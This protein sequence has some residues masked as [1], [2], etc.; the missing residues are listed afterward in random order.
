MAVVPLGVRWVKA[1]MIAAGCSAPS[2]GADMAVTGVSPTSGS[3]TKDTPVQI[4]GGGFHGTLTNNLDNGSAVYDGTLTA[5]V[6]TTT[7]ADA[8]RVDDQ[9]ISATVPAGITPGTYDVTVTVGPYSDT[10]PGAFTV[11]PDDVTTMT[12]IASDPPSSAGTNDEFV[13]S[14]MFTHVVGTGANR[15]LLVGL[16]ISFAGTTALSV[17]S[18]GTAMTRV[19]FVNALSNDGRVE[20]WRLVAPPSGSAQISIQLSNASSSTVAGAVSFAN[21]DQTTPLGPFGGLANNMGDPAHTAASM[22][23][24]VVFGVVMWNGGYSGTLSG[25]QP[26]AWNLISAD[27]VGAACTTTMVSPTLSWTVAPSYDDYWALG[28][29]AIHPN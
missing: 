15:L 25:A 16:S 26:S 11:T 27:I 29:V 24:D 5:S 4:G 22:T 20:V 13:N 6:G 1:W 14:L 17:T 8:R 21:V 9:Q 12:P 28:A 19:G 2:A 10:L 23:G 18:N 3:T 7:L